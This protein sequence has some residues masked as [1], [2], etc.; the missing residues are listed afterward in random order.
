VVQSRVS[1]LRAALHDHQRPD[2]EAQ[3]ATRGNGYTLL[4]SPELVDAH[5]FRVLAAGWRSA[6]TEEEA[7]LSLRR[8]LALWRGP[9]LG[10]D[11]TPEAQSMCQGLQSARLTVAEDLFEMELRLGNHHRCPMRW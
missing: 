11:L 5:Q 3:L 10:G 4:V 6:E 9:A 2:T 7:R 8:A 1:E